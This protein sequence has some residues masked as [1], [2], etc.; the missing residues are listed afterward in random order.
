MSAYTQGLYT[1]LRSKGKFSRSLFR[2]LILTRFK[3]YLFVLPQTLTRYNADFASEMRK[4]HYEAV[5][6]ENPSFH[7]QKPFILKQTEDKMPKK[8]NDKPI[9]MQRHLQEI[10]E[11]TKL[12]AIY[13]YEGIIEWK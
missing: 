3:Y 5:A 10:H 11:N 2:K 12:E 6:K 7:S 8:K 9:Q 4:I 1:I 13:M